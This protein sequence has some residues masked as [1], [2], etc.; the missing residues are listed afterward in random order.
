M[1]IYAEHIESP[2]LQYILSELFTRRLGVTY[3]LTDDINSLP[4][5]NGPKICYCHIPQ[6]GCLHIKPHEL[7]FETELTNHSVSGKH[8]HEWDTLMLEQHADIP[9]DLFAASFY[10]LA[11]YEEYLPHKVDEHGRFDPEQSL[12]VQYGFIETP[13]VDKWA[14][15][16]KQEL[17]DRYGEIAARVPK[18]QFISTFDID[19]AYL[20][21]GLESARQLRKTIKSASLFRFARLAEQ[22]QVLHRHQTDPYDT[23][24]YI[25]EVTKG[26]K[27]IYFVLSGG[28]SEFD[29]AIPL[30]TEA[31]QTLLK[32]LIPQHTMGV[33]FS[34]ETY[35]NGDL[36]AKE[37][38]QLETSLNQKVVVNRQHFLRFRLPETMNLLVANGITEDYSMAYSDIAGFRASTAHPFHF[39]DLENNTPTPLLL[40]PTTLMDV[41]LRFNMNL[42]L[43]SALNKAEQLIQEVKQVNGHF[44]NIWHNSNLSNTNEWLAWREVFE[45]IHSLAR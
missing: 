38:H 29:E 22:V 37:K 18:Y 41:T 11:R 34:Y 30:E 12:A 7:L 27:V 5:Y 33:H 24:T 16:L 15:K 42:T 6:E 17:E 9:F 39:F 3:Q 40:Y 4:G 44:I 45:K 13:L 14:I 10:L 31:M 26:L 1:L 25:D 19:T 2:R 35:N 28:E 20:Y 36:M 23:Y 43:S 21:K 8:S 32:Q